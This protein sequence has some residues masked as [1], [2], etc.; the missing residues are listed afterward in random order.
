VCNADSCNRDFHEDKKPEKRL[1]P[2][3]AA[4]ARPRSGERLANAIWRPLNLPDFGALRRVPQ[5]TIFSGNSQPTP[6]GE[7]ARLASTKG[8]RFFSDSAE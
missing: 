5:N 6:L 7:I 2:R 4:D 8:C 1:L 3:P